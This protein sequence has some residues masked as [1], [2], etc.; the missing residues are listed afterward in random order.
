MI[1]ALTMTHNPGD[2]RWTAN[3]VGSP[4]A[5]SEEADESARGHWL[6]KRHRA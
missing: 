6:V 3:A 5:S 2:R 4:S 1:G